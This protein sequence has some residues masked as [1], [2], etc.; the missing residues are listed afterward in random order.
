MRKRFGIA[1]LVLAIAAGLL[2]GLGTFTFSYGEG[3]SYL[4]TDPTACTN[5]HI[6]QPYFDSWQ[7]ASHHTVARCVDC[8]LPH[9]FV[10]KYIAKA[11][12]GFNHSWAFTFQDF[13][14]P[15]QIKR[16]NLKIVQDNCL[17]CHGDMVH[18]LVAGATTAGDAVSCI[19]CHS[20]VGHGPTK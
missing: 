14:E 17:S 15:I 12:N 18:E 8:H 5:C 13:H 20:D 6:M 9:S 2:L 11:D 16:R 4:S 1:F 3:L 19:H 10:P 7:K